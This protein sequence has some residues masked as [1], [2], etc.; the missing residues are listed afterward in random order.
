MRGGT[1]A[2]GCERVHETDCHQ[3][4]ETT[5]DTVERNKILVAG[6]GCEQADETNEEVAVA[7][8]TRSHIREGEED[9][10][11]NQQE[12]DDNEG[13]TT[14]AGVLEI[15]VASV[16]VLYEHRRRDHLREGV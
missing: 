16:L 3:E 9:C 1:I 12:V 10:E 5:E 15:E 4:D 6:N 7:E 2:E 8:E 13:E 11:R 14:N